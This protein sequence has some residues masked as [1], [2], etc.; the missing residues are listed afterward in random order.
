M[1]SFLPQ[2]KT[3]KLT[4]YKMLHISRLSREDKTDASFDASTDA[5]SALSPSKEER[6]A[7]FPLLARRSLKDTFKPMTTICLFSLAPIV[8]SLHAL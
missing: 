6:R 3:C 4:I 1:D 8:P 5:R 2:K 7:V